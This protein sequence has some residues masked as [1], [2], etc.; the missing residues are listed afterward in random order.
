MLKEV[1]YADKR[2][3]SGV[4]AADILAFSI[5]RIELDDVVRVS[6]IDITRATIEDRETPKVFR[7]PVTEQTL[8]KLRKVPRI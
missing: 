3:C 7:F 5:L 1:G 6:N 8:A 4:R 2:D